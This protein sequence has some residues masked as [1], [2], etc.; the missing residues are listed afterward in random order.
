MINSINPLRFFSGSLIM[1]GQTVGLNTPNPPWRATGTWWQ[2]PRMCWNKFPPVRAA[3]KPSLQETKA[4]VG[5][6][7]RKQGKS[8]AVG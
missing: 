5:Y 3:E 8:Q 4:I 7:P 6:K 2:R 1:C